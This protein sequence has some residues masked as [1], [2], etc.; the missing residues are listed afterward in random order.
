MV[1]KDEFLKNKIFIFFEYWQTPFGIYKHVAKFK[2]KKIIF[3][4]KKS[5]LKHVFF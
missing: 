1:N 2:F 5:M 4:F 3:V